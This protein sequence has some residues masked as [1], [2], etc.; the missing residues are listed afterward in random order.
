[1][2]R[3]ADGVYLFLADGRLFV[4]GDDGEVLEADAFEGRYVAFLFA[5]EESGMLDSMRGL[6][7]IP[8]W[9]S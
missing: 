6:E 7:L 1:M 9:E 8:P 2:E 5:L 3:V 4:R